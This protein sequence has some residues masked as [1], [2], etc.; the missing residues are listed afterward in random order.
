MLV[1]DVVFEEVVGV[2]AAVEE[3]DAPLPTESM[4]PSDMEFDP[5]L[6]IGPLEVMEKPVAT[7]DIGIPFRSDPLTCCPIREVAAATC[8]VCDIC[9][10]D[11]TWLSAANWL[12]N[13]A[14]LV[15]LRGF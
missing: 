12:R 11:C 1:E 14:L 3:F 5:T 7:P 10:S 8:C 2:W 15:G 9:C 6:I 4:E 13:C